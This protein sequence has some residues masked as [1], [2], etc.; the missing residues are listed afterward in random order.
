MWLRMQWCM[1]TVH[2]V[3]DGDCGHGG[4]DGAAER[5]GCAY[6]RAERQ[7][8]AWEVVRWGEIGAGEAVEGGEREKIREN[9]ERN[10]FFLPKD[11]S[12][13]K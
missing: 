13:Q 4:G 7:R 5:R 2:T 3:V 10:G 1:R 8:S 11:L 12:I 9:S 6:P